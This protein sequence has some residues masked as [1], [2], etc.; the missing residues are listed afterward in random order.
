M[1]LKL[2]EYHPSG[3]AAG[4][5]TIEYGGFVYGTGDD[6]R[7]L[8]TIDDWWFKFRE[9][10]LIGNYELNAGVSKETYKNEPS[11]FILTNI[12][13]KFNGLTFRMPESDKDREKQ[14]EDYAWSIYRGLIDNEL[15]THESISSGFPTRAPFACYDDKDEYYSDYQQRLTNSDVPTLSL[16]WTGENGL[17]NRC[18]Q[19]TVPWRRH[20]ARK[21][22]KKLNLSISDIIGS[23]LYKPVMIGSQKYIISELSIP[24]SANGDLGEVTAEL[25]TM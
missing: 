1:A 8:V 24:I 21:V 15:F 7:S 10:G 3:V 12:T 2:F 13:D 4:T 16:R 20:F 18:F 17:I 5:V 22:I 9:Y 19:T 25:L 23:Q 6:R 11:G 14:S